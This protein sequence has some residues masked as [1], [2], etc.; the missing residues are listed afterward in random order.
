VYLSER[1]ERHVDGGPTEAHRPGIYCLELSIPDSHDHE[2]YHRL[3]LAEKSEQKSDNTAIP[4]YLEQIIE[5]RRMLYVGSSHDVY[6]RLREHID[7]YTD[8]TAPNRSTT[9]AEVF[10]IHHIHSIRFCSDDELLKSQERTRSDELRAEHP[11]A[12]IHQR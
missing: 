1:I 4:A 7:A 10:P 12:Y 2:L 8:P 5:A 3:Y 6:N 11:E 9:I